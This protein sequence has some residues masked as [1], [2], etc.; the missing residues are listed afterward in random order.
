V[1]EKPNL[2]AHYKFAAW[3]ESYTLQ[4]CRLT[5][6]AAHYRKTRLAFEKLNLLAHYKLA[7]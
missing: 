4:A 7:T 5:R 1:F 2:L 3:N 6:E